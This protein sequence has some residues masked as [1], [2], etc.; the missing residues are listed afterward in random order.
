MSAK[1]YSPIPQFSKLYLDWLNADSLDKITLLG[2]FLMPV[3]SITTRHWL[4]GW[5]SLLALVSLLALYKT[6]RQPI[7][8]EEKILL[9]IFSAFLISFFLSAT[10]NHWTE[11]SIKRL[12]TES[13]YLLF[14]PLYLLV[15][16]NR[17]SSSYLFA[18]TIIGSIILGVRAIYDTYFHEWHRAVGEYGQIAFGD[19]AAIFFT[20][21][22]F[23]AI[24]SKDKTFSRHLIIPISLSL[25]SIYL[26]GARNA[27]LAGAVT[28]VLIY[29]VTKPDIRTSHLA[30]IFVPVLLLTTIL[31]VV[32]SLTSQSRILSRFTTAISEVE[33]ISTRPDTDVTSTLRGK[34]FRFRLEKWKA[35]LDIFTEA[36][37]LG[38]GAGNIGKH[39]NRYA[40]SGKAHP[41]LYDA[42]SETGI[43]GTLNAYIDSMVH[44]G[45]IGLAIF[46]LLLLYPLFVAIRLRKYNLLLSN[47]GIVFTI[48]YMIF[49]LSENPFISDNASS[50]YL[51]FLAVIFSS[52]VSAKY[53]ATDARRPAS[54]NT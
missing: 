12:G 41:D 29:I 48:N 42:P 7:E 6:I 28:L 32:V 21:A 26:S 17:N 18:G 20:V 49:G 3:L 54:E 36:P 2:L 11:N 9:L 40:K 27:W 31:A 52:L 51:L 15:R 16:R 4:S 37:I 8:K 38:H 46:L 34:S 45:I 5:F 22:S 43:G 14:L 44:E 23:I 30:G 47:I 50:A 25:L 13:K 53:Q 19:H 39:I 10:I 1:K 35:A 33:A 24:Y